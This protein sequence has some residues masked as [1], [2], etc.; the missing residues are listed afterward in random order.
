MT[1]RFAVILIIAVVGLALAG[2]ATRPPSLEHSAGPIILERDFGGRTYAAGAFMNSLT[3]LRRGFKVVLDGKLRGGIFVLTERFDYADGEK[4]VKTWRFEKLASGSYR[5]TREDVVG[6]AVVVTDRNAIRLSYDVDL[7]RSGEKTRVHFEDILARS[8]G[9]TVINHAIVSKLGL[10][11][12]EVDL[13]FSRH[14]L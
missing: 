7:P 3:G 1:L 10:A 6:S 4:G 9:G 2:C 14:P 13:R 11:V 12:G 8:E 5:G